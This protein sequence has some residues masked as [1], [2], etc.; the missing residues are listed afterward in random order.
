MKKIYILA[1]AALAVAVSCNKTAEIIEAPASEPVVRTFTCTFADSDSKVAIDNTNGKTSWE[2]GDEILVHGAGSSNRETVTLTADDISEDKKTA[3]ITITSVT[4]YDRSSDKGYI[5]T[6]YASYPASAVPSGNQYYYARFSNTNLPLM[7]AYNKGNTFVFTNICGAISFKVSGEFDTYVFSGNN[8]ETVGYSTYQARVVNKTGDVEQ[9]EI[10]Y[11]GDGFPVGPLKS[12]SGDVHADGTT[13]NS[14]YFPNGANFTAGFTILFKKGDDIVKELKTTKEVVIARNAYR[15]MGD[16]TSYLKDYIPPTPPSTHDSS[17]PL[18]SAIALDADGTANCYIVNGVAANAE[19]VYTFKAYKG[20]STDG[21][22]TIGSADIIWETYNNAEAVTKNT[23]I[24]AVDFDKQEANDFYTMVFQMPATV[25]AG[26]ALIAAKNA[27][28]DILWSWHIW[29]PA[30][31]ITTGTYGISTPAM[32]DRYL[33]ALEAATAGTPATATNIGLAYEWGRKDPFP[34]PKA[35]NSGTGATVAGTAITASGTPIS[36]AESILNPTKMIAKDGKDWNST[37]DGT[38]WNDE[39]K[40]T[41]YD[42]CPPGY[43]VP[44]LAECQNFFASDLSTVAG[45]SIDYSTNYYFTLGNPVSVFPLCGYV[46]EADEKYAYAHVYDRVSIW[47]AEA[48][49]DDYGKNID[50]RGGSSARQ[51]QSTTAK[52]RSSFIRCVEES[53][54]E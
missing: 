10:P 37:H 6:Y 54:A 16:V 23:V 22:G 15:P 36:I 11:S 31:V 45:W 13:I 43:K 51:K 9:L 20:N 53:A 28:G 44:M 17:I 52:S 30:S 19:K 7:A 26:N 18:T 21:V 34:G 39:G 50:V 38:L 25:H 48:G 42:P 41:K 12:I 46:D 4:P 47:S 35:F 32:M 49:S 33:G 14:I 2:V 1:L 24:A 40:K 8:D 27:S 5:S 29:I 3:T